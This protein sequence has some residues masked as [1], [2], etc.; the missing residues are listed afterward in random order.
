MA[1]LIPESISYGLLA[2]LCRHLYQFVQARQEC[3]KLY[4]YRDMKTDCKSVICSLYGTWQED[5]Y[6]YYIT[7]IGENEFPVNFLSV[8][9]HF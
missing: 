4:P 6:R 8:F 7:L 1:A 3:M 9:T 2:E 5:N